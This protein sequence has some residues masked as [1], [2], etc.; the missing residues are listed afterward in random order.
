MKKRILIL[1][2]GNSCRSQMAE[3]F[4]KSFDKNLEV[5]SAGTKPAEK[6]NPYAVKAMMEV[7]IDISKGVPENV[8]KYLNQSFDYVITVCD[9][10]KETCPVFIG[11]VGK[12]LH[13][14]FDDPAEAVGTEEEVMPVYRRV[15]DEIK[16]EF[17][18][19]YQRIENYIG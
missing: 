1:C 16:A 14:G 8:D 11:K 17:E 19:F 4:L 15:R 18:K 9:N 13:I 12:Q 5:Y 2:T 6:V 7:G 10:A 3:G